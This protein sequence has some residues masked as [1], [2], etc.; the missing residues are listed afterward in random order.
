MP[1]AFGATETPHLRFGPYAAYAVI[2]SFLITA[3][4]NNE[5]F[6]DGR[7]CEYAFH[8]GILIVA[9]PQI[10]HVDFTNIPSTISFFASCKTH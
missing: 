3:I 4:A 1:H 10:P 9:W 7:I 5:D 2:S 6:L 8:E